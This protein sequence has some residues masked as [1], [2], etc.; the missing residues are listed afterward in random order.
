MGARPSY[1]AG[2]TK[3]QQAAISEVKKN[4]VGTSTA[5]VLLL[6]GLLDCEHVIVLDL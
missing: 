5:R 6:E 3:A 1:S 2:T 4:H